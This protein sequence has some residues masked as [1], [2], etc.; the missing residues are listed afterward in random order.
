MTI[1]TRIRSV[2]L[3][4]GIRYYKLDA[5]IGLVSDGIQAMPEDRTPDADID[6][7]GVM[8]NEVIEEMTITVGR[9][10]CPARQWADGTVEYQNASGIWKE[11]EL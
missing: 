9:V 3:I 2:R 11:I 1:D 8:V 6:P 10:V 4:A 7:D 5:T